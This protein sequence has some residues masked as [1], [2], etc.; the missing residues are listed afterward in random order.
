MF[1]IFGE[2]LELRY[3]VVWMWFDEN[4]Y[5]FILYYVVYLVECVLSEIGFLF[6]IN[7]GCMIEDEVVM[8]CFVFVLMG[9]MF[10]NVFL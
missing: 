9:L 6:Y 8:L 7:V 1:F 4:G 5:E 2:K 3:F 10:E